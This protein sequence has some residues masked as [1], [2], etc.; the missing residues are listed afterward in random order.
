[1]KKELSNYID[2]TISLKMLNK[3]MHIFYDV[4]YIDLNKNYN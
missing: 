1:M 2:F 3:L 4:E